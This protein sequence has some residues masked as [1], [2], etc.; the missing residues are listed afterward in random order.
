MFHIIVEKTYDDVSREAF[1]VVKEIVKNV[2]NPVLGL[3]TGSS[4]IGM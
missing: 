4:P 1:K 3:A 2:E